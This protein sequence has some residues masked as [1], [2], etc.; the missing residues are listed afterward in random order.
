LRDAAQILTDSHPGFVNL[1]LGGAFLDVENFRDLLMLESFDIV[2]KKCQSAA[3]GQLCDSSFQIDPRHGAV[4]VFV[5]RSVHDIERLRTLVHTMPATPQVIETMIHGKTIEPR[6]ERRGS[7]ERRQF[8]VDE[9]KDLLQQVLRISRIPAHAVCEIV[10]PDRMAAVQL[11][12]GLRVSRQA[13]LDQIGVSR[14][15]I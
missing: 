13:C 10:E 12:E 9:K 5:L 14:I 3:L 2:E 4:E 8:A 1:R 11:F 15:H 7:L 6:A